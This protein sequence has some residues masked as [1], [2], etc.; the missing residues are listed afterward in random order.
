[1]AE[2]PTIPSQSSA[3]TRARGWLIA[4]LVFVL[5][6]SLP[7]ISYPIARD[8]ATYCVIGQGL[9]EGKHLYIDFW[10]NRS[11]GLAYIYALIVK[12]L[13]THMWCVGLVDILWL[14]VISYLLFRFTERYLGSGAAAVA[15]IVNASWH[16]WAGYWQAA[17]AETFLMVFVFASFFLMSGQGRGPRLRYFVA[18][19]V[20]GA[21]FWTKYNGLAMLPVVALL[22]YLDTS[23]L[24]AE[25]RRLGLS[26]P[27]RRWRARIAFFAAGLVAAL[28]GVLSY[29]W[30]VDSLGAFKEMQFEVLPRYAAMALERTPHYGLWAIAKIQSRLG[31]W[32]E[33]A[34]VVAVLVAWKRRELG[35]LTPVLFAAALGL[36]AVVTQIRFHDYYFETCY[37]FF[38]MIWGYLG[39]KVYQGFRSL[40]SACGARHWRLARVLVWVAFVNV[41][42]WPLPAQAVN[43]VVHYQGLAEWWR[44]GEVFYARYPWAPPESHMPDQM[45][46]ISYMRENLAPGERFF[47][48]GNEP[49]VYFLTRRRPPTRF[50]WS[51]PLMSPWS[52][53]A[54][55]AELV[56]DLEKSLPRFLIV[57][58]HD[59]VPHIAYSSRDS[60]EFLRLYPELTIFIHDFYEP[61]EDLGSFQIYRRRAT[62]ALDR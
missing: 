34:T 60:E 10:D 6:R 1:M 24:D 16:V 21:A 35:Q 4:A 42:A 26:L 61:A 30:L 32:T 19:L 49:L 38:A 39:W 47:L 46:M 28:V 58:R 27:W 40:A 44:E 20:F 2:L 23:R 7:N 50:N 53:P 14:L 25:P 8:Q 17:Q 36:L 5:I 57:A 62:R 55:R 41:V 45:R 12:V 54:W 29:F 51:L 43:L 15:V 33:V 31:L 3:T 11:P 56:R 13:G 18:G 52:P 37:P 48:W 22:P 9:L 59:A